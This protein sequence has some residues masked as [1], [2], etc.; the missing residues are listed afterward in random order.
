LLSEGVDDF[1]EDEDIGATTGGETQASVEA[2]NRLLFVDGLIGYLDVRQWAFG[3]L[4]SCP[5][6]TNLIDLRMYHSLYFTNLFGAVDW[7]GEYLRV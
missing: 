5:T 6:G 7:V 4:R 1:F 2:Y 3:K